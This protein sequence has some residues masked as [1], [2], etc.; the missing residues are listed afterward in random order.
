LPSS[1]SELKKLLLFLNTND[2]VSIIISGHTDNIG[3]D[4]YNKILSLSRARSVAEWLI[5][6]GVNSNRIIIEGHGSDIPVFEN[7]TEENRAINRRVEFKIIK[8]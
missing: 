4:E 5:N 2:R 6:G 8:K 7:R 3:S 1:F